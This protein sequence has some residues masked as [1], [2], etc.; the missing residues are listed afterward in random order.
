MLSTTYSNNALTGKTAIVTGG[1]QG[2]GFA[3]ARGFA[4][5]GANVVLNW[6]D[7]G[8]AAMALAEEFA[9]GDKPRIATVYGDVTNIDD[10]NSLMVAADEFGG[11][12]V[13]VNNAAV[14][15]RV[16]FLE[17]SDDD[18]DSLMNI[19]LRASFRLSRSFSQDCVKNSRAGSIIN[20]TSGAA[21]RS[22]PRGV[23]YVT[24]KAGIVGMTR[25]LSLELAEHDI[26]A[27]AI[28]PGL[29]DTAQPRFGM[30]ESEIAQAGTENPL[31]RIAQPDDIAAMA[32]FLASAASRHVT[33]QT[34]HINGG[35]YLS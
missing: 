5:A 26:R 31:G 13:L 12:D 14:F 16:S 9:E 2:I 19:N 3:I 11:A 10:I 23:H 4:Q 20:L 7:N 33:G 24:S 25:A 6:L 18:W 21:F 27:N 15:P 17:M 22:S 29:T 1:Q 34:L 30:T 28:A 8:D 32:I 35:Q